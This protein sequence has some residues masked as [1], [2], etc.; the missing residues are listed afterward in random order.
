MYKRIYIAIDCQWN[1]A[2]ERT[3]RLIILKIKTQFDLPM[4]LDFTF[5]LNKVYF[6]LILETDIYTLFT[7]ILLM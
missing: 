3:K 7:A 4:V 5:V 6:L 2:K 1:L